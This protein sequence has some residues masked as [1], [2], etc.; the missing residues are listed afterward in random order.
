ML[1]GQIVGIY[2]TATFA[3]PL[4]AH[5][6]VRAVPGRGIE[7]DRYFR[8]AGTFTKKGKPIDPSQHATLIESEAIEALRNEHGIEIA[9]N[10]SRRNFVTRGIALNDLVGCQFTVGE[11]QLKG[12]RLCDPCGH[13]EKLTKLGVRKG[14]EL[15]GGLRAHILT[16]GVIRVGDVVKLTEPVESAAC[17]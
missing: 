12:I 1:Q 3:A 9:H 13:L 14:L 8:G 6:S 7:G 10:E 11:V 17:A 5:Q 15:R 2:T 16:E 4:D